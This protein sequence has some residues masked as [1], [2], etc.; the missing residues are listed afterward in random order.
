MTTHDIIRIINAATVHL[1]VIIAFCAL[2]KCLY[3]HL[4]PT[5]NNKDD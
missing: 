3:C 4:K 2:L 5:R 1:M